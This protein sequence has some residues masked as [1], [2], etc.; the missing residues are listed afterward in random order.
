MHSSVASNMFIFFTRLIN[1]LEILMYYNFEAYNV[2]GIYNQ[3]V[4]SFLIELVF[5]NGQFLF[6]LKKK[7]DFRIF[8]AIFYSK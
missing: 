6:F 3:I 5:T 8:L 2:Y 7:T 4:Y 1:I